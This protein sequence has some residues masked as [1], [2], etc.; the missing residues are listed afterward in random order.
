ML[1][2]FT[3][4]KPFKGHEAIIQR[5]AIGSWLRLPIDKEVLLLGDD[6][7]LAEVASEFGIQHLTDIKTNEMGT[8]LV[9]DLFARAAEA[10]SDDILCYVNADIILTSEFCGALVD[11]L[12]LGGRFLVI[13]RR[14]DRP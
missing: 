6:A 14:W 13:G 9:S 8:P 10:S 12:A 5:N 11:V 7:G 2:V 3:T 1:T 4:P